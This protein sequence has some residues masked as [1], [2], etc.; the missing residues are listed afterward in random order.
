M[1]KEIRKVENIEELRVLMR[2]KEEELKKMKEKDDYILHVPIKVKI[3]DG[4][5]KSVSGV[6]VC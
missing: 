4:R 2:N 5:I 6:P 3:V 1:A